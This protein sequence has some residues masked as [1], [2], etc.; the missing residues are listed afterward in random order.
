MRTNAQQ[1]GSADA[2]IFTME[3]FN[4]N[5]QREFQAQVPVSNKV[6]GRVRAALQI[7]I[8]IHGKNKKWLALVEET[9]QDIEDARQKRG[10]PDRP[11]FKKADEYLEESRQAILPHMVAATRMKNQ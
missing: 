3:V 1:T 6:Q 8:S 11:V 9:R 10:A 7:L 2:N 5:K 4:S